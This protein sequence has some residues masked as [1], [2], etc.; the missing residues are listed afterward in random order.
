MATS[1][2]LRTSIGIMPDGLAYHPD[3]I[4]E[5]EEHRLVEA[6]ERLEFS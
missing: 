4:T 3:F 1:T 2:H 5:E 6:I